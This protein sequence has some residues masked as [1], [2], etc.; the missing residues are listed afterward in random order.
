MVLKVWIQLSRVQIPHC[1][2]R[3]PQELVGPREEL[4]KGWQPGGRVA[5]GRPGV[6]VWV[7]AAAPVL[8]AGE[9]PLPEP[10]APGPD[11]GRGGGRDRKGTQKR[12]G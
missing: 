10:I 2:L 1:G 7:L 11:P 5:Q 12:P 6:L 8:T 9:G 4:G 3:A